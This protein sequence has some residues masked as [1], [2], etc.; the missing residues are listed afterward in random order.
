MERR[1]QTSEIQHSAAL[2]GLHTAVFDEQQRKAANKK[3]K[4]QGDV[5]SQML[6]RRS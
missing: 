3:V 4:D 1:T 2:K 6:K 5:F